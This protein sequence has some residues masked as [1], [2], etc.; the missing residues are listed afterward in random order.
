MLYHNGMKQE[1]WKSTGNCVYTIWY[2]IVWSTKYRKEIL[3][4]PIDEKLKKLLEEICKENKYG[5]EAQEI[6][7]DHIHLF[8]SIPPAESL[9]VAVK[10]LKGIS[11]RLLFIAY[12]EMKQQLWGGHLW[13]PSYYVGTAGTVSSETIKRYI[14][15]Q[16]QNANSNDNSKSRN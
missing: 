16:K 2:H 9:A 12:P 1:S 5:L 8:L 13:N 6:M 14:A 15:S 4:S 3:L 7:P 11:A 10:K